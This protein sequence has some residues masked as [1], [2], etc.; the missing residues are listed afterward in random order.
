MNVVI[1]GCGRLGSRIANMLDKE[2]HFVSVIDKD[3]AAFERLSQNFKGKKIVGLGFDQE[4]LR[5]AGIEEA[6]A[7][8]AVARGD[9]HNVVSSYVARNVYKVPTVIAR[10]YNPERARIYTSMGIVTISPVGWGANAILDF[11]IHPEMH[12]KETFGSGEVRLIECHCTGMLKGKSV[13]DIE[14]PGRIKV[15][16]IIKK[17]TAVIPFPGT[18]LEE[19]DSIVMAVDPSGLEK[20]S[21]L[22]RG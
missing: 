21:E 20:I 22:I 13:K 11:I 4:T 16:S 6:D 1:L 17:D 19:G 5:K 18:V 14:D 9:N 3:P 10:I 12:V 8:V 15:V 7:F 2:G